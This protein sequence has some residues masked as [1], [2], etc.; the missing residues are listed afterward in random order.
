VTSHWKSWWAW[1]KVEFGVGCCF[2]ELLEDELGEN[3]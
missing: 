2:G 1:R 3:G